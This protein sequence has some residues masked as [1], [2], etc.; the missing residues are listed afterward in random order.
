MQRPSTLAAVLL[1]LGL[2]G[3]PVLAQSAAPAHDSAT[4]PDGQNWPLDPSRFGQGGWPTS[5]T[6]S[7]ATPTSTL[8]CESDTGDGRRLIAEFSGSAVAAG[9]NPYW[10]ELAS[11]LPADSWVA[12][13][14]NCAPTSSCPSYDARLLLLNAYILIRD[15]TSGG[16][17]SFSGWG[18]NKGVGDSS[19]SVVFS[20]AQ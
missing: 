20:W 6:A 3:P 2:S 11:S 16:L 13:S 19:G 14:A 15:P 5:C 8:H 10:G 9:N 18:A 4:M 17:A 1:L 12:A 7:S